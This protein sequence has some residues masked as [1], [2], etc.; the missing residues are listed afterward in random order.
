M[1]S[2][3]LSGAKISR[4]LK[5]RVGHVGHSEPE[6]R[7]LIYL[8]LNPD[9]RPGP[10]NLNL[11]NSVDDRD[12]LTKIGITVIKQIAFAHRVTDQ[13]DV[14]DWLIVRVGLGERRRL[15]QVRRQ[16]A[17]RTRYSGLDVCGCVP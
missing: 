7:K 3:E 12:L 1:F 9:R 16:E 2:I 13:G 5:D 11:T 8:D 6:R 15:R 17:L 14:E 4:A 10:I